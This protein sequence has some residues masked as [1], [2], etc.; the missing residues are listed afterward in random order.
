MKKIFNVASVFVYKYSLFFLIGF[1]IAN[2]FDY[3]FVE[4][5]SFTNAGIVYRGIVLFLYVV[6]ALLI[7]IKSEI[8]KNRMF[9]YVSALYILFSLIS[10]VNITFNPPLQSVQVSCIDYVKSIGQMLVNVI[11]IIVLFSI[12]KID[13]KEKVIAS[14]IILGIV[15][16]SI[17]YSLIKDYDSIINTF[18]KYDHSNYDVKSF[19]VDK[20]TFGL[21]LFLGSIISYY[22]HKS[23]SKW[24]NVPTFLIFVYSIIIRCKTAVLLIFVVTLVSLIEIFIILFRKNKKT[25]TVVLTST[26]SL[27]ALSLILLS[28]KAGPFKYIYSVLFDEYGLFY[29]AYIVMA[30]RFNNWG[31]SINK[32]SLFPYV[33]LGF[34]ERIYQLFITCPVDN[35]FILCLLS[36]G[37]IKLL[38]YLFLLFVLYKK[39]I[40][41]RTM[42][43]VLSLLV[44]YG[45]MQDYSMVGISFSSI[46]FAII[47]LLYSDPICFCPL[48][49]IQK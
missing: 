28:L 29:D 22:L 7:T 37:V 46:I 19:F 18:I 42:L 15:T 16:L 45:F 1:L 34:S 10:I 11:S 3:I 9:V 20:N 31:Y 48:T 21:L 38:I 49:Y 2:S 5:N 24:Y 4:L 17:I 25:F 41:N 23:K 26:V 33:L 14:Y 6:F 40:K 32:I 43:F 35:I 8:I 44:L 12:S 30:D 39:S 13:N 36:G 27:L 47:I